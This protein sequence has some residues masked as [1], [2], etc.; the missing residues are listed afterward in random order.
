M[1][2]RGKSLIIQIIPIVLVLSIAIVASFVFIKTNKTKV[3][4]NNESYLQEVVR[5][6]RELLYSKFNDSLDSMKSYAFLYG[7]NLESPE[8]DVE[9]LKEIENYSIFDFLYFADLNGDN[10]AT[11]GTVRKCSD[12]DYYLKGIVGESGMTAIVNSRITGQTIIGCYSTVRYQGEVIGVLVGF[13]NEDTMMEKMTSYFYEYKGSTSIVDADRNVVAS[14][15]SENLGHNIYGLYSEE[16]VNDFMENDAK[17]LKNLQ[18]KEIVRVNSDEKER[19]EL[20]KL[21]RQRKELIEGNEKQKLAKK[22][23]LEEQAF[24]DQKEYEY[25]IKHQIADMEEERRLEEIKKKIFNANGEE[26]RRQIQEKKEKEKLRLR[27]IIEERREIQQNLDDYKKTVERI[28]K[29]KLDEMERYHIK[30][31]YRVDL[32]RYKIK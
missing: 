21:E 5:Q 8:V 1:S 25:I 10:Y 6:K 24:A 20:L 17:V 29:E 3:Q 13:F 4:K 23:R 16:V 27:A 22:K 7:N 28:K 14:S 11:N 15:D 2:D 12:R 30:P 31:E 32:Q 26:V 19:E 18:D 9:L